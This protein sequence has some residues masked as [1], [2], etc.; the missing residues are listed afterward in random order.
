MKAKYA[1]GTLVKFNKVTSTNGLFLN[2][3]IEI[4][5]SDSITY[6]RDGF[7]YC[8]CQQIVHEENIVGSYTENK[9]AKPRKKRTAKIKLESEAPSEN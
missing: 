5:E 9:F 7:H 1:I 8:V 2:G 3:K 6:D 4:G